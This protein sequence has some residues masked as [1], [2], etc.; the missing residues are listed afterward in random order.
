MSELKQKYFK[1]FK[2]NIILLVAISL[3]TSLLLLEQPVNNPKIIIAHIIFLFKILTFPT[4]HFNIK[5]EINPLYK[6]FNLFKYIN[7]L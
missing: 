7:F 2:G 3:F 1:Q 5:K 4:V 6:C